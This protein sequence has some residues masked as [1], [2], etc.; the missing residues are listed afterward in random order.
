MIDDGSPDGSIEIARQIVGDDPR[1]TIYHKSNGGLSDARNYGIERARGEYIAFIDSDD[2]VHPD[3]L[4]VLYRA[5]IDTGAEMSCC[6]YLFSLRDGRVLLPWPFPARK[7][8]VSRE[9][10][11]RMLIRDLSLQ[12]MAWNK[13]YRRTLFTDTGVR[14]PN[15]CFEDI[16]TSERLLYEADKLAITG[17]T[18]YYYTM[19]SGSIMH[20]RSEKL[21]NDYLRALLIVCHHLRRKGQYDAFKAQIRFTAGKMFWVD[22]RD[23]F[24]LHFRSRN[25]VGMG[26]NFRRLRKNLRSPPGRR[27]SPRP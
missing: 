2:Y 21:A 22:A 3:Y 7:R 18:L 26:A 27:R 4:K 10:G 6:Q 17:K 25:F 15:M 16:A 8:V 13:L 24:L 5:C 20:S 19:R 1:F 9:K 12:N 14:Y 11:I 23:I